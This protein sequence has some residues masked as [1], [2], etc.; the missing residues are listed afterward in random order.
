M[1]LLISFIIVLILARWNYSQDI[2]L[3]TVPD[4]A[5]VMKNDSLVGHTPLFVPQSLNKIILSKTGYADNSINLGDYDGIPVKLKFTGNKVN[6]SFYES[7]AFRIFIGS[8][9]ALGAVTAY[10]KIKA[11]NRFDDYRATG[12]PDLLKETRRYD[13]IS[14]ISFAALQINFGFLIYYLLVY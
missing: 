4:D 10:F 8:I 9:V 12:N 3:E 14:G 13:L 5:Y 6:G 1:K 2:Y 11:D 7:S